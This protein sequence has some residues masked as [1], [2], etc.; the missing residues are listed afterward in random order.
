[1]KRKQDEE[2]AKDENEGNDETLQTVEDLKKIGSK[3][4]GKRQPGLGDTADETITLLH[5]SP[6]L[7]VAWD[8]N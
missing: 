6:E 2:Q 4:L 3:I 7:D 8:R 1:V 5:V